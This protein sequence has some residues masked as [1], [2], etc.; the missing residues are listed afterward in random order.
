MTFFDRLTESLQ[1]L[2]QFIPSL[3]GAAVV[4]TLGYLL[5]KLVQR[6]VARV[7][8]RIHLNDVLSRGGVPVR[9]HTGTPVN[10]T[11]VLAT[12]A[13][14][15]VLFTAMLIAADALGIDYLGQVFS[16]FQNSFFSQRAD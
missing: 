15:F 13:F 12:L 11:R 16:E 9:D 4:L 6:G 5:A 7:L 8:R 2:W 3:F 10:P 1:R 14:W